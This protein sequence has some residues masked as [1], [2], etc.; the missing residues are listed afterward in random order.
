MDII[1]VMEWFD[2]LYMS[3]K[4]LNHVVSPILTVSLLMLCLL[5]VLMV[6]VSDKKKCVLSLSINILNHAAL[7]F[8]LW[9]GHEMK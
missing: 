5:E 2:E 4:L 8:L 1:A 6:L 3:N 7:L 9:F